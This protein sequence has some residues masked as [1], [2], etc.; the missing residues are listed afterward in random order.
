MPDTTSEQVSSVAAGSGP[1]AESTPSKVKI[2]LVDDDPASL[3]SL[4][5]VLDG[6]GQDL[7]FAKSG[8][9]ALSHVL[10]DDFALILLDVKMPEMDGFETAELIRQRKR[11]QR[12]PILF[13]TGYQSDSHLFRGYG[14]GAVDFLVKPIIPEVLRS[15]VSVFVELHSLNRELEKRVQER[16]EKQR[17]A[18]RDLMLLVEASGALLA[19]P[20]TSEVVTTIL[21]L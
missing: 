15:K 12:T 17:A 14:L 5:A 11:S 8:R 3:M 21:E 10:Q 20:R 18:E 16:T 7:V 9:E 19:S 6:L 4:Q 2:L 13:L 1:A